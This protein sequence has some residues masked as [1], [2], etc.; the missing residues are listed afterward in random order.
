MLSVLLDFMS[1]MQTYISE[2][3][4][5]FKILNVNIVYLRTKIVEI[6]THK[7]IL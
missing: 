2:V 4:H 6:I 1:E 5:W 7:L 3:K